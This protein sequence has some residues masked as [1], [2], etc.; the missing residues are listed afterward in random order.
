MADRNGVSIST[1][2]KQQDFRVNVKSKRMV[3]HQLTKYK[4]LLIKL[5]ERQPELNESDVEKMLQEMLLNFEVAV[6]ENI[7]V[8]GFSWDEAAA[9]EN[10][11]DYE[12]SIMDDLLDE[13]IVQTSW[14]R[15]VYPKKILPYF[16]RSLKAER[17]LMSLFETAVKP[18]EVKRDPV[19]DTVMSSVSAAAPRMFTQASTVMKSLKDVKQMAEG[20]HQVLNTQPSAETLEAYGD[21]FCCDGKHS[22]VRCSSEESA[23]RHSIKRAASEREYSMQYAPMTPPIQEQ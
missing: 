22:E 20:L 9:E 18:Q 5:L 19:Q 11:E 3:T 10:C 15:S 16:V 8:G 2:E 23:N 14:K 4:S 12:C 1:A 13:K 17:K 6:Q 7:S 21:V